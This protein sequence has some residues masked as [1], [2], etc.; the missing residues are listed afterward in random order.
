MGK[1][2]NC[3]V[4]WV[5][6]L[7]VLFA[8]VA[9]INASAQGLSSDPTAAATPAG[10][11]VAHSGDQSQA[12][13]IRKGDFQ[14]FAFNDLGMHC[15]DSD[16]SVFSLLPPFNVIHAQ[17]IK[18][19]L[20]P[21]FV[22]ATEVQVTYRAMQD[23]SK[24]INTTSRGKTNFWHYVAS[25]FG[26]SPPVDQGLLGAKMPGKD[27]Q[28]QDFL[29]YDAAMKWFTAAGIPITDRDDQRHKN[30]MPLMR[31]E[32]RDG[33]GSSLLSSLPV[34]LPVSSEM[35]CMDCHQNGMDGTSPEI[36]AKYG[37]K[38]WSSNPNVSI[39]YRENVLLLHDAINSTTLFASKPVLCASCHYS[40]ALDL[41]KTGPQGQ[42]VGKS[43]LSHAIHSHHGKTLDHTLPDASNP[44]IL[45]DEGLDTCYNCHPGRA[46][47]CLRGCMSAHGLICQNCH[48]G[49]LAVGG[50]F[51]LK[52]GQ[53]RDPWVD[54]PKCQSCHTGDATGHKGE[55]VVLRM[56]YDPADSAATPRIARNQRFAENAGALY[57]N[58]V[59]HGGMACEA[60][61]GSPHGE[62][63]VINP[64][65]NDNMAAQK[66]QGYSGPIME[67]AVCH[68]TSLPLTLGG[69]HGMH[70]MND[71]QWNNG[72]SRLYRENPKACQACH[73]KWLEGSSL[74]KTATDRVLVDNLG[75]KITF[76]KGTPIQCSL[77]H[78]SPNRN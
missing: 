64:R 57:R 1:K 8:V 78:S 48:G 22:D 39:Q 69:P 35:H 18:R 53:T 37:I 20:K 56:A 38:S 47:K 7:G 13:K 40:H 60:C 17:V 49:M 61:H 65:A 10:V 72:H 59:T 2:Q 66:I 32:V 75:F 77:C 6:C 54:L 73:G 3:W 5:I 4:M 16:F 30:H 14:V 23:R 28:P 21:S 19:G 71:P 31:V 76:P 55:E 51:P 26:A 9:V 67:C 24:S 44:P 63:P 34:V 45:P 25:L 46:T 58:S 15:Y 29:A 42:Q 68:G 70:N 74:S 11:T 41:N 27:N 36:K 62:W 52:N 43:A 50:V 33:T 12:V